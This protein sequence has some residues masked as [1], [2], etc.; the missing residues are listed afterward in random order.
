[1]MDTY[2]LKEVFNLCPSCLRVEKPGSGLIQ[3]T[4]FR[5]LDGGFSRWT[6]C[7][8]CRS[9]F[10]QVYSFKAHRFGKPTHIWGG[11]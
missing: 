2:P 7:S 10:R 6:Y 5:T 3:V 1:M 4:T 8:F 11:L 9:R